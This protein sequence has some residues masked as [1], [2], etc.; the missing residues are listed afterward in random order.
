[1]ERRIAMADDEVR[2]AGLARPP[3]DEMLQLG[4]QQ[5]QVIQIPVADQGNGGMLPH[6]S[7]ASIRIAFPHHVAQ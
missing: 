7:D 4:A 1:M 5:I 3:L 2:G 6:P